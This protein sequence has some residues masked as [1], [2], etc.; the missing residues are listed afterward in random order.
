LDIS[1]EKLSDLAETISSS[2]RTSMQA[3]KSQDVK[4]IL[5]AVGTLPDLEKVRIFSKDGT[6]LVSSVPGERGKKVDPHDLEAFHKQ[7]FTTVYNTKNLERP[8]F[9]IIKPIM[10]E[11]SCYPCHGTNPN[12]INGVLDVEVSMVGVHER[13][14]TV[15]RFMITSALV[16]LTAL[17]L[18][19]LFLMARLVN[20]PIQNLI[21]TIRKAEKG[22]LSARV[23]PDRT[24]EF[25]ELGHN[26][27]S[28][29]SKLEKAQEDL[30]HLHEE[31]MERV[32]RFATIGELAAGIAHEIKNP[33]AGIGGAIQV[34][35]EELEPD[36]HRREI[37]A[38]ILK[39][40]ERI[41]QD[42]K[43]LLSYAR[44]AKPSLSEH[45]INKVVQQVHFLV[46]DRAAQ[47]HVDV[48]MDLNK[49]IPRIAIDDKQIQQV[50]VNLA[51]NGI[52]AMPKGGR[53]ILGTS[54]RNASEKDRFVEI[55]V[56][57]S[58]N[59][60]PPEIMRKIFTPFFTTRHTGTGL[61]LPISQKIVQQHNGKIEV[62]SKPGQETCFNILLPLSTKGPRDQVGE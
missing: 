8:I 1:R 45:D 27:N 4:S 33:I 35:T 46:R 59:G 22:D 26:F 23:E 52:Q 39:Q 56:K 28:M 60:I 49:N 41:N 55:R 13:I 7:K 54:I 10:N 29:I 30:K 43:D 18:S 61:G 9:Y 21:S 31:Q 5:E 25:R 58:G 20:N 17:I 14:A 44:T 11:P 36:D 2:I 40:I 32:D 3:G 19:I 53:L 42:V 16:T 51:L 50:L 34:L 24:L 62:S 37:F 6:V 15:R 38:E 48:V 12:Q 57:D 47:Q